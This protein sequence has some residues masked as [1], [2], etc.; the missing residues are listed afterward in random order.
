MSDYTKQPKDKEELLK[1]V[2]HST[3]NAL[4][5][6]SQLEQNLIKGRFKEGIKPYETM[7]NTLVGQRIWSSD[8]DNIIVHN[9]FKKIA[10]TTQN[11]I[12]ILQPYID[13]LQKL[14][15]IDGEI[16]L[17]NGAE[18]FKIPSVDKDLLHENKDVN[19]VIQV[20]KRNPKH[21]V[22]YTKLRTELGWDNKK[23]DDIL[24]SNINIKTLIVSSRKMV[25]LQ[26]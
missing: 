12:N 26:D 25:T 10:L 5:A 15:S 13:N 11:I 16:R 22:S 1:N 23:L 6:L 17:N 9:N 2:I 19:T 7:I 18:K 3:N 24:K 21:R 8:K 20:I 4:M 14:Q